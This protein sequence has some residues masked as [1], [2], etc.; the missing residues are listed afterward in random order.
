[1]ANI[2][3]QAVDKL[4]DAFLNL[5]SVE[6]CYAF[7]EDICTIK[8]IQDMSQR[9]EVAIMLRKGLNY[10][11]ISAQTGVSTATISRVSKCLNY[12]SGGYN[13]AIDKLEKAG[14]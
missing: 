3:S 4:F 11:D 13:A 1:M 2:H 5:E 6:E 7:F 12:G 8:E 9:L 10:Q 14:K